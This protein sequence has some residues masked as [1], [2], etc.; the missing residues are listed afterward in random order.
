MGLRVLVD[1]AATGIA[2]VDE[3]DLESLERL[4]RVPESPW[5]RVN[6]VASADGAATGASGKSGSI[7]NDVDVA[8]FHALRASCDAIVVGAGTAEIEGYR[9]AAKP[10]VLVSRQGR[11]PETLRDAEAGR[12]LLA[13]TE[14]SRGLAEARELLGS[15]HVLVAG[16]RAIDL[17]LLKELLVERGWANLLSEGGPTLLRSFVAAGVAD[18]L[19]LTWVPTLVGGD[20]RRIL[21][22]GPVEV[23]LRLQLLLESESTLLGRWFLG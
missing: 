14:D 10:L 17:A 22:G 4:Y 12:V 5:L 20:H 9:P 21:A 11:I 3:K 19:C 18:E 6:M 16:E 1:A 2:E 7:N 13:T 15:E 23:G 8:V